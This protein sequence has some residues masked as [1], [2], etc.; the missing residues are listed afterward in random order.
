MKSLFPSATVTI[1]NNYSFKHKTQ[2]KTNLRLPLSQ[3]HNNPSTFPSFSLSYCK[4]FCIKTCA[5]STSTPST[6]LPLSSTSSGNRHWMVLMEAPP[7]RVNSKQEAIEYYVKTLQ[8]VLGKWVRFI[9]VC[10]CGIT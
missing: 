3:T 4:C 5:A 8:R 10:H 9:F 2:F 1:S 7:Q 6:S